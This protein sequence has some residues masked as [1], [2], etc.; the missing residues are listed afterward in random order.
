MID[1]SEE[2][3][4][5]NIE[6]CAKYYERMAKMNCILEIELGITGGEEDGVDNTEVDN[7]SL[8]S[9]PEDIWAAYEALSKFGNG[10]T[11]AASFGNVHG[12]YK[13]CLLARASLCLLDSTRTRRAETHDFAMSTLFGHVQPSEKCQRIHVA[14][15][16]YL[17]S[18]HTLSCPPT[19]AWQRQAFS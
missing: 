12:V 17:H 7:A 5:E 10:F 6:I 8:Y 11:I 16:L 9:Q 3:I 4:A 19:A 14:R 13:V 2:P 18:R 1:L 15:S